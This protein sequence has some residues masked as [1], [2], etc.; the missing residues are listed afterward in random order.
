M[1]TAVGRPGAETPKARHRGAVGGEEGKVWGGGCA[2]SPENFLGILCG[3]MH[4]GA[5][6][7]EEYE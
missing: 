5:L 2:P 3:R 1:K 7:T 4:F 6:F